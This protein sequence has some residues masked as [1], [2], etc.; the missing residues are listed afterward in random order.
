MYDLSDIIED[1]SLQDPHLIGGKYTWRERESH[2]VAARLDR[3]LF[4]DEWDEEFKNI[5]QTSWLKG[6]K[7]APQGRPELGVYSFAVC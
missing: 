7:V 2:D 3:F 6:F 5:K 1:M 4:S